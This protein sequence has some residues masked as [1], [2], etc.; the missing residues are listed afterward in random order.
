M[1]SGNITL[2]GLKINVKFSVQFPKVLIKLKIVFSIF[3]LP[4]IH[5]N[6]LYMYMHFIDMYVYTSL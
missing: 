3:I 1:L 2:T 5:I 6:I 4:F